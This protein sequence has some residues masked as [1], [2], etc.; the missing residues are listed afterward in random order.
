MEQCE[1]CGGEGVIIGTKW[2]RWGDQW[3]PEDKPMECEVC[4]G[5]GE[6]E[7]DDDCG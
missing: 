1:E 6:V 3:E 5:W 4:H 2:A 7:S